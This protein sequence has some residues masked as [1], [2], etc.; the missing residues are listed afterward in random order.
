MGWCHHTTLL[1][2]PLAAVKFILWETLAV[3]PA[4]LSTFPVILTG[5]ESLQWLD[6]LKQF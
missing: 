1:W 5:L 3:T 6:L 4:G 2:L